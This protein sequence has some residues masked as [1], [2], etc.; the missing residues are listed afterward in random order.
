MPRKTKKTL[1]AKPEATNR[2]DHVSAST[3][4]AMTAAVLMMG[5]ATLNYCF[6]KDPIRQDHCYEH[7]EEWSTY[8]LVDKVSEL[9]LVRYQ[10]EFVDSNGR[11]VHDTRERT[12]SNFRELYKEAHDCNGYMKMVYQRLYEE[13]ARSKK[14]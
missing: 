1:T 12:D 9:G 4:V 14:Q 5:I 6:T 13:L 3:I 2:C 8:A 11:N 10:V 7:R